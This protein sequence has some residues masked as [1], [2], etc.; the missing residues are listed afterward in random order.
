MKKY[1]FLLVVLI[2]VGGVLIYFIQENK[3]VDTSTLIEKEKIGQK[4]FLKNKQAAILFSSTIDQ[5]ANNKGLSYAVFVDDTG[6][7]TGYKMK[8]LELGSMAKGKQGVLLVDKDKI[9]LVGTK[10]QEFNMEKEQHTGER[11]GYLENQN[12][13]FSIFNTGVNK[14]SGENG[15]DSNVLFGNKNGF[16]NGNIPHYI[17]TSGIDQ[18]DIIIL[19][20][21]IEKKYDLKKVTITKELLKVK[22]IVELKNEKSYDYANLSQIVCDKDFYYVVLSEYVKDNSENTVLLRINKKTLEQ[23]KFI[24][25]TY[26]N[27]A[28]AVPYNPRNSA[29][30]FQNTFYYMNG[31]GEVITFNTT[32]NKSTIKFTIKG[33]RKDGVRRN[34]GTYFQDGK[35]Y[36]M[37]YNDHKKTKYFIEEYSLDTGEKLKVI[38]IKGLDKLLSSVKKVTIHAYD[39]RMLK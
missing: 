34:E 16:K 12:V 10:Y 25:A 9:R 17:L 38:N 5:D 32:T 2:A 15:Y 31:L 39:F 7:A 27:G 24:L 35:L 33:A 37:R 13:Y 11:T 6:A 23:E 1:I 21:D 8:S 20:N 29:Y 19:T 22:D 36:V 18:N 30:L 4:N 26:K 3:S 28:A 14:L